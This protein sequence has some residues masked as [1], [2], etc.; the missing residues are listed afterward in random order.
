MDRNPNEN[1]PSVPNCDQITRACRLYEAGAN[2]RDFTESFG[3]E[4]NAEGMML[5]WSAARTSFAIDEKLYAYFAD[6]KLKFEREGAAA[7]RL[8]LAQVERNL[9]E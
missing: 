2:S 5:L 4:L 9:K 1:N 6:Q 7:W 3:D 8:V